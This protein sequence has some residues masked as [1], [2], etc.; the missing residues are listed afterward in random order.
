MWRFM[1]SGIAILLVT[2]ALTSSLTAQNRRQV[3]R[4][5]TAQPVLT[6]EPTTGATL[7][8][9]KPG[10][11]PA[12]ISVTGTPASA[13]VSW[14]AAPNAVR[15]T[16]GR[17]LKGNL[18]CCTHSAD[19]ITATTWT[20]NTGGLQWSGVYVYTV[21][22]IYADGSAGA[23]Q[24]EWTRPEPVNPTALTVT[25]KAEGVVELTWPAVAGASYYLLWGPGLA[26]ATRAVGT[27]HTVGNVPAGTH[28]YTVGAYFD[29]G[30]VSTP[31]AM[32]TK[33]SIALTSMTGNYRVTLNGFAVNHATS[34]DPANW[35]GVSDEVY[36]AAFVQVFDRNSKALV[37]PPA[38]VESRVHGDV[39][40]W[41]DR[42][43]AGSLTAAGGI[44]PGDRVPDNS[45]PS[46]GPTG[47][48][49]ATAFPLVVFQGPLTLGKEV[50]LVH[51]TLWESDGNRSAFDKWHASFLQV[52]RE[53]T[54]SAMAREIDAPGLQ[55]VMGGQM[56]TG[57]GSIPDLKATRDVK[58]GTD[59]PIGMRHVPSTNYTMQWQDRMVV[60][61]KEKIDALLDSKYGSGVKGTI[62]IPLVDHDAGDLPYSGDYV[63]YLRVERLP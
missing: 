36:G 28:Q 16:V 33:G 47:Q 60:I 19:N 62:A 2:S 24:F 3:A 39:S 31:V 52:E 48:P 58:P 26:D 44:G 61:T 41:R 18:S 29:P 17:Y 20:D 63:L 23:A 4:P 12:G 53:A 9:S 1:R 22:A 57:A 25:Q 30:P 59:R 7:S 37:T 27:S 50:V 56:L 43:R 13:T 35:D 14:Q 6:P 54:F 21:T 11:A 51:P 40:K 32:F 49:S 8:L 15:Y 45:D 55:I 10:P 42:V 34:E 38:V 46:T 5:T